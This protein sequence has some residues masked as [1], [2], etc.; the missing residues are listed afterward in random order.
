MILVVLL[1]SRLQ[2]RPNEAVLTERVLYKDL[3]RIAKWLMLLVMM[4]VCKVRYTHKYTQRLGIRQAQGHSWMVRGVEYD[5]PAGRMTHVNM[6]GI[7]LHDGILFY[8][9]G[10]GLKSDFG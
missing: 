6:W 4:I 5:R 2:R 1:R 8:K 9:E 7:K 3:N 10:G